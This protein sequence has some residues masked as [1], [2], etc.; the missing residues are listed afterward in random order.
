MHARVKVA[1]LALGA[2]LSLTGCSL[3]ANITTSNNY[4]A[5]D[6]VGLDVAEISAKN[7]L[8]V[9][10]AANAPAVLVGTLYNTGTD[11]TTV[12][13]NVAGTVDDVVVPA[14]GSVT[15][16]VG[17]GEHEFVTT[18]PV[19]PGALTT[20]SLQPA[21]VAAVSEPLPVLDGT[22]A[23]YQAVLDALAG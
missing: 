8:L 22:L 18:S 16:G 9:T 7:L 4:D 2:T 3:A 21:S 12:T 10:D 19:A 20:V 1:A 23:E 13:I 17:E 11:A 6:G 15:L 5:S 14:H